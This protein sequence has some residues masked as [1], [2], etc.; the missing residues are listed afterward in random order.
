MCLRPLWTPKVSPTNCGRIVERR[1]QVLITSC[2]PDDPAVSAFF[3]RKPSTNGPFHT[4]RA[5][6]PS[7]Y[8]FF[9]AW[10]LEMMNFVVRFLV[11]VFFPL[12]G[13]PQRVTGGRPPCLAPS[14]PPSG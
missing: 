8:F 7:P 6:L 4:E 9:R 11:R 3:S 12:V 1:L 2:R 5:I 13:K 10:R 14:P